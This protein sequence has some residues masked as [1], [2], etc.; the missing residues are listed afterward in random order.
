MRMIL[1]GQYDS[2]FVRRVAIPLSLYG[3]PFEHRRWSVVGDADKIRPYNPLMRVPT[4]V[5]DDG[6]ALCDAHVIVDYVDS[7]APA[8]AALYPATQPER[9]RAMRI[10]ALAGGLADKGV[11]LFYETHL[12]AHWSEMWVERCRQQIAGTLALLEQERA[13]RSTPWWFG[14][15]MGH[16]DIAVACSIRH[17]ADSNPGLV[18]MD[19]YPALADHCARAEAL[20]VFQ[21][22]S[23]PFDAPGVSDRRAS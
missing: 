15:R 18:A 14:E 16:A 7:L 11:A 20:P 9:H 13:A 21:A 8:G 19:A 3:V 17:V 12:H 2:S 6:T 22:H 10:S 4:L 5:L 1:I 23:Q